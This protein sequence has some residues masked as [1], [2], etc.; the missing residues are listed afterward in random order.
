MSKSIYNE[1][2]D[3]LI[4]LIERDTPMK[5]IENG[6]INSTTNEQWSVFHCPKCN[7]LMSQI[8]PK[9][10]GECGQR[11]DWSELNEK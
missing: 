10:C 11:I 8:L 7:Y 2:K 1:T 9:F 5:L 3:Y 4:S 6:V